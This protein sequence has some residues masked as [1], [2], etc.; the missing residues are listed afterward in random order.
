M[1]FSFPFLIYYDVVALFSRQY[2]LLYAV[3]Q[4]D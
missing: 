2:F 1:L 3:S 4:N